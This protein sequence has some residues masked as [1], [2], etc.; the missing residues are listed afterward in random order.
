MQSL[1][2][3]ALTFYKDKCFMDLQH[4]LC[5][6]IVELI[7]KDREGE[8]VDW[9]LLKNSI[10]AFVHL[11]FINAD[12]LKQDDDYVWRGDKNLQVYETNFEREFIERSRNEYSVKSAGWMQQFNCPEY[13]RAIEKHLLKEEERA[14]YF[15]QPETKGK[16]L[17]VIQNVG[18]ENQAQRLV[19]METGCDQM[20]N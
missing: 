6:A 20:F 11:G 13:L 19:E 15:L 1:A 14:N 9:D 7:T 18:I 17:N 2:M 8:Y 12:I 5:S 4:R 3:S 10:T 16:L